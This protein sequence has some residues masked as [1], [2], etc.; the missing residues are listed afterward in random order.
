MVLDID[1]IPDVYMSSFSFHHDFSNINNGSLP[2]KWTEKGDT[3]HIL[4]A[5]RFIGER[6][7]IPNDLTGFSIGE[8]RVID[9][10]CNHFCLVF[11]PLP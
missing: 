1:G 5:Y 7:Q 8:T 2:P 10:D 6:F 4:F 3:F 9:Q 11:F